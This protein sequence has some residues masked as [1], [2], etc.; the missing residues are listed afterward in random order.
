MTK[1]EAWTNDQLEDKFYKKFA[2][3]YDDDAVVFTHDDMRMMYYKA[4]YHCWSYLIDKHDMF[5]MAEEVREYLDPGPRTWPYY[6]KEYPCD[7]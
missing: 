1:R 6:R 3:W 7:D 5:D 4:V 2:G